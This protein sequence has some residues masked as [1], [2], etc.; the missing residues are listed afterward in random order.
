MKSGSLFGKFCAI[1]VKGL[2][3]IV[4]PLKTSIRNKLIFFFLLIS[5]IPII[6]VGMISYSSSVRA[7]NG[8]ITQYSQ[9]NIIQCKLNLKT[10]QKNYED[11]SFQLIA[12]KEINQLLTAC[13]NEGD[14]I[15]YNLKISDFLQGYSFIHKDITAFMF[16]TFNKRYYVEGGNK[17]VSI[18][19]AAVEEIK[20]SGFYKKVLDA[21]GGAVWGPS[22]RLDKNSK[23]Y[24]VMVA[25]VIKSRTDGRNLGVF[26]VLIDESSFNELLNPH[27]LRQRYS[28][29]E[30]PINYSI[31]INDEGIIITSP[32]RESL[33]RNIAEIMKDPEKLNLAN[34][35][36]EPE[37][38][39]SEVKKKKH[40]ITYA[41][42]T[43]SGWRLLSMAPVDYL[44]KETVY[45]GWITFL[46]GLLF[47]A[48]A[49]VISLT[50]SLSLSKATNNIY[51]SMKLAENGNL[52]ARATVRT[53]DE[54][55]HLGASF[56]Q[57]I[58][59]IRELIVET[60]H[61]ITEVFDRTKSMEN[62]ADESLQ[63][64]ENV[65]AAME[66]ISQGTGEQS[67]EAERSSKQ[68][69]DLSEE[70]D[71]VVA[72]SKE[73]EDITEF[74]GRLSM[75]TQEAVDLLIE[76]TQSTDEITN[77]M[78]NDIQE[79][80]ISAEKIHGIT[81]TIA[82]IAEQTN[83][84]ALNAAIEA[85]RA[86][87]AGSGFAVVAEEVNKLASQSHEA[88][89]TI[90]KFLEIIHAK[91]TASSENVDRARA[92]IKEQIAAVEVAHNAF[93]NIISGMNDVLKKIN[94]INEKIHRIN[95]LKGMTVQS[96]MN[97]SAISEET[98]ASSQEIS[99]SAQEQTVIAGEVRNM[100]RELNLMAENLVKVIAN[101]EI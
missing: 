2:S 43:G 65:A 80:T 62:A 78:I 33:N 16:L 68:M 14:D 94:A 37:P 91:T 10:K 56:N 61:L 82:A 71:A 21:N 83:L 51:H 63:A 70:I 98:A 57:M 81:E 66:E 58:V 54:L 17:E 59:K 72:K 96:I 27:L 95:D 74:T 31:I 29:G 26:V 88:V 44:Y 19:N 76:K 24:D 25:R 11:I 53:Q 5:L 99:A 7:I 73:I 93:N 64:A 12:N 32:D 69:T 77:I 38:F 6:I 4:L 45:V 52:K 75:Q 40:L 13:V 41:A 22:V 50:V 35:E 36:V 47:A 87:E 97:I 90:N 79:L 28:L 86:G 15:F 1:C 8:K 101:F 60:K 67:A 34:E 23:D 55:G 48:I 100:A 85:A 9:E 84:L 46:V 30:D 20:N 92:T 3:I 89:H 42:L 49:V 18:T 39:F